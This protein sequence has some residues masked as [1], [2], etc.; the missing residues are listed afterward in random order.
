MEENK[1]NVADKALLKEQKHKAKEYKICKVKEK[2]CEKD[3]F[4]E[5]MKSLLT[6]TDSND[7]IAEIKDV[8]NH[9]GQVYAIK[10]DDKFYGINIFSYVENYFSN[11]V[12]LN[13]DA[14]E[15][16]KEKNEKLADSLYNHKQSNGALV[17]TNKILLDETN[18]IIDILEKKLLALVKDSFEYEKYSGIEWGDKVYYRN[19]LKVG[20]GGHS[21]WAILGFI[22]GFIIGWLCFDSPLLGLSFAFS[23]AVLWGCCFGSTYKQDISVTDKNHPSD[24][25]QA[26]DENATI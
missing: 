25:K 1:N 8:L 13:P 4:T 10:K 2:Q 15:S 17:L 12:D 9:N 20:I 24:N 26:G 23:Y 11:N 18:E 14:D 3:S 21:Y 5:S 7:L 19:Y 16:D 6:I 22:V